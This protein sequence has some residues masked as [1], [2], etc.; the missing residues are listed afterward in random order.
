ML[1][2]KVIRPLCFSSPQ[3]EKKQLGPP[4]QTGPPRI[5]DFFPAPSQIMA[6]K[7]QPLPPLPENLGGVHT[8]KL[9]IFQPPLLFQPPLYSEPKSMLYLP[10][11]VNI[12]HVWYTIN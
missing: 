1:V 8:M 9:L 6:K 2:T 12:S 10:I 5:K 7:S 4:N 11:F 3:R